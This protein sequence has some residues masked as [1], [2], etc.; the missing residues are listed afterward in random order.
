MS[1]SGGLGGSS[2][3][4]GQRG[5]RAEHWGHH[6]KP[7]HPL[8]PV[9]PVPPP[10]SRTE[11]P[12]SPPRPVPPNSL[13]SGLPVLLPQSRMKVP[14]TTPQH[15]LS[16]SLSP[17]SHH[18]VAGQRL[19]TAPPTLTPFFPSLSPPKSQHPRAAPQ[20]VAPTYGGGT[21]ALQGLHPPYKTCSASSAYLTSAHT[22]GWGPLT[23]SC[24]GGAQPQAAPHSLAQSMGGLGVGGFW[25]PGPQAS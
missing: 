2:C 19:P 8:Y 16:P 11:I 12:N 23:P 24:L 4:G 7:Q 14:N 18:P 5:Q 6:P 20:E 13:P 25:G 17:P 21:G 10:W 22:A 9:P 15:P 3:V 1:Q